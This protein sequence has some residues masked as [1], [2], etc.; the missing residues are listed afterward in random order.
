MLIMLLI[1]GSI[2]VVLLGSMMFGQ[3]SGSEFCP[4]DFAYRSFRFNQI[5]FIQIQITPVYRND[6]T[7]DLVTYLT[8]NKLLPPTTEKHRWDLTDGKRGSFVMATSGAEI[9][10]RYLA[11]LDSQSVNSWKQWSVRHPEEAKVLWSVVA[12]LART[13]QYPLVPEAFGAAGFATNEKHLATLLAERIAPELHERALDASQNKR[14]DEARS[15]WDLAL[16][17]DPSKT[18]WRA[19]RDALPPPEKVETAVS[20]LLDK[21]SPAKEIP[22]KEKAGKEASEKDAAVEKSP[23]KGASDGKAPGAESSVAPEKKDSEEKTTEQIP[24]P[25][26]ETKKPSE[27]ESA[28]P[29]PEYKSTPT[30]DPSAPQ[31]PGDAK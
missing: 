10:Q 6:K 16:E 23:D 13:K 22:A 14:P 27:P 19:M 28:P 17:L 15:L 2:I 31:P 25:S 1:P 12:K 11:A 30:S 4:Q 29:A 8:T 20:E 7:N 24:P 26:E 5:P 21:V 18:E 9:L 3:V